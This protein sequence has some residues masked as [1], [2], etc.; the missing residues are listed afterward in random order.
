M[1]C[2]IVPGLNSSGPGHWQSRWERE[3]SDCVRAELG[4]WDDPTRIGWIARLGRAVAEID[5][6]PVIVAHSLGCLA[7]V[8]WASIA[9]DLA[10]RVGG[11]LL[12]AP[13]D[14]EREDVDPRVARF[15]P[16][17]R[18]P[19]PFPT[20]VVASRNDPYASF[21]RSREM[22][23]GWSARFHDAGTAGHMNA[24]SGLGGWEEGQ[25]VVAELIAD[26]ASDQPQSLARVADDW[27]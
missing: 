11:A 18:R 1:T 17:P 19:L 16:V 14:P 20:I 22:A 2:L 27:R 6:R 5:G 15:G 8:W 26:A 3:R 23:V 7:V 25:R 21:Q 13:P 9:G 4:R 10:A 12:V 24:A